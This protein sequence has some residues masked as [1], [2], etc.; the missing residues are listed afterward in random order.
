MGALETI[1]SN[2]SPTTCSIITVELSERNPT[3]I[4][5]LEW[6]LGISIHRKLCSGLA[7]TPGLGHTD[8]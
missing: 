4:Y 1:Y 7:V 5:D 8:R 2:I 3:Q 6:D